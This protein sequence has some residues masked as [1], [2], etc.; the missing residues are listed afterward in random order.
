MNSLPHVKI[1]VTKQQVTHACLRSRILIVVSALFY[2][3]SSHA[4]YPAMTTPRTTIRYWPFLQAGETPSQQYHGEQMLF[5]PD[6]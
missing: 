3:A 6:C 5:L 4:R 1:I 2:I